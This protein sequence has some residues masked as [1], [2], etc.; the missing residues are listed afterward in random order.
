M[1]IQAIIDKQNK[2]APALRRL[3]LLE[4]YAILVS[5]NIKEI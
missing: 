2:I 4:S 1:H 3:L 5:H